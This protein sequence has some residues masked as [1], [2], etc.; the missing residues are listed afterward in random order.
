MNKIIRKCKCGCRG[1]TNYGKKYIRGHNISRSKHYLSRH[2][3]YNIWT[4]IKQRCLNSKNNNFKYY[5]GRG[6]RICIRWRRSFISFYRWAI[7]NGWKEG[8]EIDR[9][10]NDGNYTP[11]NCRIVTHQENSINRG[12]YRNNTS[13]YIGVNFYKRTQ[14]YYA[15]AHPKYIG[16]FDNCKQAAI[17]RDNYIIKNNLPHKLNF[18]KRGND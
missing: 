8:L 7:D 6:I 18:E 16:I 1:I 9:E 11:G 17:A 14:K 5:G 12:K 4:N 3:L 10:D 13:G 2:T 15:R